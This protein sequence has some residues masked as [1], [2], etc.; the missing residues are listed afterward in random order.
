MIR[1]KIIYLLLLT[2]SCTPVKIF[3]QHAMHHDSAAQNI[4]SGV[5]PQPLLA[6]AVRLKD[7]LSFLGSQLSQQDEKRLVT[8]QQQPLNQQVV[9]DVQAILDPYGLACININPEAR[10]KVERGPA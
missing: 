3:A 10:V 6:Q 4:I 2:V 9:N 8:L 1:R 7:A 5:E